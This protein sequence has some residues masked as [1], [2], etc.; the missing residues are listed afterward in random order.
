[1]AQGADCCTA[2]VADPAG[3]VTN[4][5]LNEGVWAEGEKISGTANDIRNNAPC[6][7]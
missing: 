3:S 4:Y 2:A 1:M 7:E 5:L 6:C